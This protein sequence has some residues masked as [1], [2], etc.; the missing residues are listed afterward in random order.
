[1]DPFIARVFIG[2]EREIVASL[3]KTCELWFLG[4]RDNTVK[5]YVRSCDRKNLRSVKAKVI[6]FRN[7]EGIIL[8]DSHILAELIE[9]YD[10]INIVFSEGRIY[11]DIL[12]DIVEIL[13]RVLRE[14]HERKCFVRLVE[15][16]PVREYFISL[17]PKQRVVLETAIK[18]GYF[19]TP[20]RINLNK[21]SVELKC[22]VSTLHEHL[23]KVT[24][25]IIKNYLVRNSI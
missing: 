15:Q 19:D 3:S 18:S 12:V 25:K 22:S 5:L 4:S 13:K 7:N 8:V 10:V 20:R 2:C 16:I 11:V 14:I 6:F 24:S 21:L 9:R 23:R 17:T 1:M